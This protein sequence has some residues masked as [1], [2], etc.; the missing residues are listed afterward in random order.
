MAVPAAYALVLVDGDETCVGILVHRRSR[1]HVY[2]GGVVAMLTAERH[3]VDEAIL[4]VSAIGLRLPAAAFAVVHMSIGEIDAQI[5]V[6]LA[7]YLARAAP[8][9][10]RAV[11]I[12][13][14]LFH[15]RLPPYAFET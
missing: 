7:S 8:G 4:C 6:V 5:L 10:T 13:S 11:E 2:A 3:V 12:E 14:V 1:T 9:A 15:S